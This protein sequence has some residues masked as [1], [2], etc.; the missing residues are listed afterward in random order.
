MHFNRRR[1]IRR[2]YLRRNAFA[3]YSQYPGYSRCDA[4]C[5]ILWPG[6]HHQLPFTSGGT[7]SIQCVVT[8]YKT[9]SGVSV[10][11]NV[12]TFAP[13]DRVRAQF[14]SILLFYYSAW[15][16]RV[17]V[18]VIYIYLYTYCN[19]AIK[20]DGGSKCGA[21]QVRHMMMIWS[22]DGQEWRKSDWAARFDV[23]I[24]LNQGGSE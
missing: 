4:L 21:R 24:G 6:H 14:P 16:L 1:R 12:A 7:K 18:L 22:W 2:P 3:T 5:A 20:Y 10:A 23:P 13:I 19:D 8:Y 15:D 9:A 11:Y 17:S